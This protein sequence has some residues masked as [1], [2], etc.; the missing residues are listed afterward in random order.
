MRASL[1][2]GHCNLK[3][4]CV[5]LSMKNIRKVFIMELIFLTYQALAN[6][7]LANNLELAS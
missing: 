7:A 2:Y 4:S 6:Q 1:W 5:Q 3:P